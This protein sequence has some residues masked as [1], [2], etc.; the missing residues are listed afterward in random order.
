LRRQAQR[1]RKTEQHVTIEER[2]ETTGAARR[3]PRV[4]D[5]VPDSVVIESFPEDVYR[6]VPAVR[7]YRYYPTERGLRLIDPADRGVIEDIE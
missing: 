7:G 6:E 3:E 2:H 1:H 4:G 5:R